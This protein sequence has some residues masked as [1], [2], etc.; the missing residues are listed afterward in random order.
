MSNRGFDDRIA[1]VVPDLYRRGIISLVE[2]RNLLGFP[3]TPTHE[4]IIEA[5]DTAGRPEPGEGWIRPSGISY[6]R[7]AEAVLALFS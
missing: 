4:Q 2:A 6:Q 5:M 7:M 1:H 3:A